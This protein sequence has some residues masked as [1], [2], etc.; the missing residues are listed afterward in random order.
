MTNER[1]GGSLLLW[2]LLLLL[3]V[4]D[5]NSLAREFFRNQLGGSLL[6]LLLFLLLLLKQIAAKSVFKQ[7]RGSCCR[8]RRCAVIGSG[9]RT[10]TT[11]TFRQ[12]IRLSCSVLWSVLC[13]W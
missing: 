1:G 7:P 3:N 6:L 4:H 10:S 11:R 9:G 12:T 13:C 5:R 2:L 8:S